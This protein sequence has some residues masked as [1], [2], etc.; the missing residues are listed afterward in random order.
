MLDFEQKKQSVYVFVYVTLVTILVAALM[1]YLLTCA[2]NIGLCLD[3]HE[4]DRN[5]V[6]R[7]IWGFSVV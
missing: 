1:R 5:A 7:V 6:G 4:L 3:V 2:N